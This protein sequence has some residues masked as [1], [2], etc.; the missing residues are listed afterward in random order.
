MCYRDISSLN[1][2]IDISLSFLYG[3]SHETKSLYITNA[4][5]FVYLKTTILYS[6]KPIYNY[7]SVILIW[8]D[9]SKPHLYSWYD[10]LGISVSVCVCVH[11][12]ICRCECVHIYVWY[13]LI[14]L[15]WLIRYIWICMFVYRCMYDMNI[16]N[17]LGMHTQ[18]W[19][20]AYVYMWAC[21]CMH[22]WVCAYVYIWVYMYVWY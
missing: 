7:F 19:V 17:S 10:S 21:M 11:I 4:L 1:H 2:Y 12:R 5:L 16:Y 20:C 6:T 13:D 14:Y 22:M 18:A 8:N 3:F 9:F 15:I